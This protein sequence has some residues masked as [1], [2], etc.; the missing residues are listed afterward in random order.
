M[1]NKEYFHSALLDS[2]EKH[3][4]LREQGQKVGMLSV[5]KDLETH[6]L[7]EVQ[8]SASLLTK[9]VQNSI[10]SLCF[11][12]GQNEAVD[13]NKRI[14]ILEV[15]GLDLPSDAN[16]K[17]E[18]F[19]AN[20]YNLNTQLKK[21][22]IDKKY[23]IIH[24]EMT[25]W[26][27]ELRENP[28]KVLTADLLND[29]NMFRNRVKLQFTNCQKK[30]VSETKGN[31]LYKEYDLGFEDALN[32]SLKTI[33]TSS[34]NPNLFVADLKSSI[35]EEIPRPIDLKEVKEIKNEEKAGMTHTHGFNIATH[36]TFWNSGL[37]GYIEK[38]VGTGRYYLITEA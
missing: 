5:F 23:T 15:T 20:Q 9:M 12:D 13:T 35:K 1:E 6:D 22:L 37:R 19:E 14:T 2:L 8:L 4:A 26:P 32:L 10:L 21:A 11:S 27:A 34:P 25:D 30:V 3:L 7:K 28:C 17:K 33:P 31:S 16:T 24:E 29:S 36:G 38:Y 18:D